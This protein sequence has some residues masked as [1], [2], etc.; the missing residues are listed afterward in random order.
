MKSENSNKVMIAN[1][2]LWA[3]AILASAI[4]TT[5]GEAESITIILGSLWLASHLML[6]EDGVLKAE[7]VCWWQRL[8]RRSDR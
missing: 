6:S 1:A 5:K 7:G 3:A 8:F 2:I 4:L